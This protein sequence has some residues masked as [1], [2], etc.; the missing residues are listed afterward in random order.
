M[1]T[2]N[3]IVPDN[4]IYI[5]ENDVKI[6]RLQIFNNWSPYLVKDPDTVWIGLEYFCNVGDELWSLP[7][8]AFARMAAGELAKMGIAAT[9]DVLDQVVIR[10]PKTYPGVF[11]HLRPFRGDPRLDG[12]IAEPVP[13]RPQR[14]A[15]LQQPGPL[16]AHRHGRRRQH[17]R[18]ASRAS[19]TSG[20]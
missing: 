18:R 7:D 19:R 3:D 12:R 2:V 9:E 14:H 20:A 10:V 15:S 1:P 11:R 17:R 5:Q 8:D 6:G 16:D 13:R 4:W